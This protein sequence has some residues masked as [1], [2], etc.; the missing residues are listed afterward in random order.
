[1]EETNTKVRRQSGRV[2]GY[3]TSQDSDIVYRVRF[4]LKLTQEDFAREMGCSTSTIA[5]MER[6]GRTPGTR[7]LKENLARLAKKSGIESAKAEASA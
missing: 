2:Q 5:K 4:A 1:M 6:E 3:R 7:A